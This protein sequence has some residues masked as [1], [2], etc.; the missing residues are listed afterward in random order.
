MSNEVTSTITVSRDALYKVLHALVGPAH[1][2]RELQ[3]TRS[4]HALGHPNPIDILIEEYKAGGVQSE[5]AQAAVP[6]IIPLYDGA[7]LRRETLTGIGQ[8]MGVWVL[9]RAG[10]YIRLLNEFERG[11]VDAAIDAARAQAKEGDA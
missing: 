9:Y 11:F 2:I 3:A 1:H 5:P 10:N 8:D 4:L 7:E 6:S